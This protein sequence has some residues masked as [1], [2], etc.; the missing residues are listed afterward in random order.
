[1]IM[2]KAFLQGKKFFNSSHFISHFHNLQIQLQNF[3]KKSFY[4][5]S[6]HILHDLDYQVFSEIRKTIF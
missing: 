3:F 5:F 1:M 2:K 4:S 6:I